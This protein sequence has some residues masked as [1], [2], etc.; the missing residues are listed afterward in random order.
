M[1]WKK[2]QFSRLF[3]MTATGALFPYLAMPAAA[4]DATTAPAPSA[5]PAPKESSDIVVTATRRAQDVSQ[6]PYNISAIGSQQIQRTGATSVEDLSRQIPNLVT[7][8]SGSQF[9][10]AQ[11]QIMRGLNASNSNRLGVTL[12]QNP[13]STYLGNAPFGNF[14]QVK[15]LDHVEV[16]RGP[17]GTLY[18][19][20]SLGG[21]IRLIPTAPK[22]GKFGGSVTAT[23]G[24]IE[25][26]NDKDYGGSAVV[27]I[28]LG[29]RIAVR[30]GASHSYDGGY[31]DQFGVFKRAG[32]S[33][34]GAP[35]LVSP[36]SPLTSPAVTY[37][38]K[39]VNFSKTTNVRVAAR[40]KPTDRLDITLAYNRSRINGFGPNVDSPSYDGGS[41][42]LLP[43]TVYPNTGEYEVVMRGIQPFY[44]KSDMFTADISY[45]FGFATLSS[46]SSWFET[47]GQTYYD[48]TWG[49]LA[50]PASYLPYYTGTPANPRFNSIQ[51]YDDKNRVYTQE[52]RLVSNKGG[53]IDY[54]V[55]AFYQKENFYSAWN[56]YDPGQTAYNQ[57]AGVSQPGPGPAG[58]EEMIFSNFGASRFTDKAI[59]GEVTWHATDRL[60][61]AGGVRVFEQSFERSATNAAP[62]FGL[63]EVDSNSTKF[64][65]KKFRFNATFE[66]MNNQRVYFTFSQGFRR[67]GANTFSLTG[68]LREPASIRSYKPD[69]V[70]NFELGAKGRL[71]NGLRYSADIFLAKWHDPQIGGFTAVN[72][73]PVVFNASAAESKGVELELSGNIT[74]AFDF[75]VGY[76]YTDAKLTK[77]FCLPSGDGSGRPAPDGDIACAIVGT[78]GTPLPSAPKHSGTFTLNYEQ[79]LSSSDKIVVTFNGNYKSSTEQ[80]L[81]TVGQRYPKVPSYWLFNGY[82]AWS[83][84]PVTLAA[85]IRNMFDKRVVYA[86]NTRITPYAPIDLYNTVGR[87]RTGGLELTFNW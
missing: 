34:L 29:D 27:N 13:V 52:V 3:C 56:G 10:G 7:T 23:G 50:L 64:T 79:P 1:C 54:I 16:L 74:K 39:D 53:P 78:K 48:G 68:F 4:Q 36:G 22:L 40:W 47:E 60:D 57:L 11:R 70:D 9:V 75:S 41:D 63:A 61:I 83:T 38:I 18:G 30:I 2:E 17:Q 81:P 32:D 24:L 62:L 59:F 66:Y 76:A 80:I 37:D 21:A 77:D 65:D 49:T 44:R 42:P 20:G 46:S 69:S 33:P 72:F 84:G 19:A 45:D 85:Y 82:V 6:I 15:D 12:E 55:G 67:G 87:P 71:S 58:P 73:W 43:A 28:P 86:T 51:R 35:V 31:I 25:H 14:F 26:S 5:A 8:S